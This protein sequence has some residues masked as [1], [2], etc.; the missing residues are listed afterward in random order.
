MD[1]RTTWL[2]RGAAGVILITSA[3]IPIYRFLKV[4]QQNDLVVKTDLGEKY[5]LSETAFSSFKFTKE[6]LSKLI[7][8]D[9]KKAEE[10]EQSRIR[11]IKNCQKFKRKK[12]REYCE[13]LYTK[14][15]GR[16][17]VE[18]LKEVLNHIKKQS[19]NVFFVGLKFRPIFEDLMGN[20]SGQTYIKVACLNPNID[21][22]ILNIVDIKKG[23]I[24]ESVRD[25][26][27]SDGYVV[28]KFDSTAIDGLKRE[29][30]LKYDNFD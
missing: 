11:N 6:D 13:S 14:V 18:N 16:N 23:I 17:S 22:K 30:C 28:P 3:I 21:K 10:Y 1:N 2:I 27:L 7:S 24:R 26:N 12:R 8:S 9:L 29:A 15:I 4:S 25:G 5:I 20:R 19:E